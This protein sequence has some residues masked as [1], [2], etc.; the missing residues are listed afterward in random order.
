ML[1]MKSKKWVGHPQRVLVFA[2]EVGYS[3]LCPKDSIMRQPF[4]ERYTVA[5]K[6]LQ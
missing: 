2:S 5:I 6:E 3:E 1:G 4:R